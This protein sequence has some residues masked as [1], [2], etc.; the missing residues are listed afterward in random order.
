MTLENLLINHSE[1]INDE[2]FIY[3]CDENTSSLLAS[4]NWY[5]DNIL[6]YTNNGISGFTCQDNNELYINIKKGE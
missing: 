5:Q 2:T 1:L 4:G 3:I 6:D